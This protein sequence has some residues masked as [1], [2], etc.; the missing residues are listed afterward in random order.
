MEVKTPFKKTTE[1]TRSDFNRKL[2]AAKEDL[3]TSIHSSSVEWILS[4]VEL[5][6]TNSISIIEDQ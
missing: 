5:L 4:I 3:A 6:G 2:K 1:I